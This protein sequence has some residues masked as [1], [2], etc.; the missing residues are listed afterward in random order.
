M[1]S[2]I[3]W[4]VLRLV[5]LRW[6][7]K[8]GWLGVLV[9]IAMILKVIG[10]PLLAVLAVVA[11]PLL[12]LLLLFGLPIFLVLAFGG[13]I[14]GALA[15]LLMIG[16]AALKFALFV[17]LPIWLVWM[18][19]SKIASMVCRRRGGDPGDPAPEP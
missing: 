5:A 8:L 13:M 4:I 19:A 18:V 7:F 11:L 6:F 17:V 3:R 14:M 1:W 2:A 12:A 9:P 16:V 15:F 10:L